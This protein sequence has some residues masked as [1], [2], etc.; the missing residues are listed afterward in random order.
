M[1]YTMSSRP[2]FDPARQEWSKRVGP[3]T[4][5]VWKHGDHPEDEERLVEALAA[6]LEREQKQDL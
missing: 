6:E 1:E 4:W 2:R 3:N 5:R